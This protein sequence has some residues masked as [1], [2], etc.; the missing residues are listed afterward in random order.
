MSAKQIVALLNSHVE[1][2]EEQFLAIALQVA[3]QAARTGPPLTF[4]WLGRP[5]PARP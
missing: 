4:F 2:D 5:G 1:G 3:A